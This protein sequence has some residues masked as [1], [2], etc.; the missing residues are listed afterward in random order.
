MRPSFNLPLLPSICPPPPKLFNN[1]TIMRPSPRIY[2]P[3]Q[4]LYAT[5]PESTPPF[6]NNPPPFKNYHIMR[7][8]HNLPSLR[9]YIPFSINSYVRS[10]QNLPLPPRKYLLINNCIHATLSGSTPPC[11]NIHP[12][13]TTIIVCGPAPMARSYRLVLVTW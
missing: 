12:F 7:P 8:S 9:E 5:T 11:Q 13:S 2:P 3:F 6:H 1:Y 4:Q 10:S